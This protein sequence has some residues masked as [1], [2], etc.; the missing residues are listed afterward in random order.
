MKITT[1]LKG[2]GQDR[3]KHLQGQKITVTRTSGK[4]LTFKK[5]FE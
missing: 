1:K 2:T 5:E 3:K 4:G